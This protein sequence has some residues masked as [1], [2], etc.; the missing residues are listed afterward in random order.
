MLGALIK[1]YF[2]KNQNLEPED[3]YSVA[4]MPCT[5]KK[6]EAGRPEMSYKATTILMLS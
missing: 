3:I 6:F 2:S 5:A 4:I 1:N